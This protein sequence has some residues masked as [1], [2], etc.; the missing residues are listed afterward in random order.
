MFGQQK[1][2]KAGNTLKKQCFGKYSKNLDLTIRRAYLMYL[3]NGPAFL[4]SFDQ[5]LFDQTNP[6]TR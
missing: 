2:A 1:K 4:N 6:R 5:T 3:L